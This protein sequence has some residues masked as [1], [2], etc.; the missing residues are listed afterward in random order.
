M[1]VVTGVSIFGWRK[2]WEAGMGGMACVLT[3]QTPAWQD[4]VLAE[5]APTVAVHY[6]A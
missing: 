6:T 1:G 4:G 5:H 3:L 2:G